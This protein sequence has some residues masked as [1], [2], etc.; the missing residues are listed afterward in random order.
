MDQFCV[1]RL[2]QGGPM[3][4]ALTLGMVALC[5]LLLPSWLQAEI[6][7]KGILHI[8]GGYRYGHHVPDSEVVNEW[9][10][11]R[12]K[13]SFTSSGWRFDYSGYGDWRLILDQEKQRILV[14]N[15]TSKSF[16]EIPLP[17]VL[18]AHV[19]PPLPERLKDFEIDGKVSEAGREESV[20][21]KKCAVYD[22]AEWMI[23]RDDRFY[24]RR[25]RIISTQDVA[26]DWKMADKIHQWV[27]SFF[28]PRS[29]Y[30]TE[31]GKIRGFVLA[32]EEEVFEGGSRVGFSFK[33]TEISEKTPPADIYGPPIDF[34][35]R[36]KLGFLELFAIRGTVY[37][38]PLY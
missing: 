29:T 3:R 10:F 18:T 34:L 15:M 23:R 31:L 1:Q 12:D 35:K 21:G 32:S 20:L 28:N 9:W 4:K 7:V 22:V 26:F 14:V 27:A 36:G 11:G 24:D 16:V 19:E 13:V 8:E 5:L 6:Y 38:N 25:R 2:K 17:M 33:V 30:L 37:G